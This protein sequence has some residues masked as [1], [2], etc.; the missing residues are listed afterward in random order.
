MAHAHYVTEAALTLFDRTG[1]IHHLGAERRRLL[2]TMA[3]LH[4]VGLEA[5]PDRHHVAGRDIVLENGLEGL[6]EL[7][8]RMVAAAVYLHR[9]R[10][11]RRRLET[12]IVA[13]LPLGLRQDTLTLAA[14]VRMADG[15]DYSQSQSTSLE[16]VSVHSSAVQVEVIGPRA[17]VDAARALAKAD[18]W[19]MVFGETPFF[20]SVSGQDSQATLHAELGAKVKPSIGSQ[21]ALDQAMARQ[22]PGISP[23][24]PMWEA[25][26]K[27]LL[28]HLS[29]MLEHEPGTREGIDI[30]ELH[31]MRVA[32]RRMRS[33]FRTFVSYYEPRAIRPYVVG[34]RRTARALGKVRDLDVFMQK[35]RSYLDGLGPDHCHD[36]DVLLDAWQGQREQS[37]V[38]MIQ[39]LD[40][41]KYRD[42]V[43]TFTLFLESPGAG[44]RRS[45]KIPPRPTLVRHVAPQL[46]YGRWASVQAFDPL[47]EK[48][49]ISVLH[50]LRIECKRL[51]YTLEF[52][53]EVLAPEA[54]QVIESVVKLQDHL[55]NLNDA[56]VANAML[57][58]F[59]FAP[60]PN[61]DR[62][63]LI[64]P[65]VVAYLAVKQRELQALVETFPQV[66]EVFN[67]PS[68]RR[69]LATAIG[70]L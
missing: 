28:F 16:N 14:L 4:N 20:F 1:S 60:R 43:R 52:F 55:G 51:R 68:T 34:L 70:V 42:F 59:L 45:D 7:E 24:D 8:Q 41:S 17:Q 18:L 65:G 53:S 49:P 47:L 40:G 32:T 19:E 29:R 44:A 57:S 54:N 3:M 38:A 21:T 30:E 36:L 6:T 31:D 50:A 37:R 11:R 26:R 58:D 64:A 63:R 9:K 69:A 66:W 22:S 33:A 25:G 12:G 35:A 15:L 13:S 5:D 48:A 56:D 27:V 46:I 2:A 62:E 67:Q 61:G 23:D 10:M 39:V